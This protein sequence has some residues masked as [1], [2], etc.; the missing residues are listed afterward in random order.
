MMQTNQW[1]LK[2][3]DGKQEKFMIKELIKEKVTIHT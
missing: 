2:E 3:G 1:M